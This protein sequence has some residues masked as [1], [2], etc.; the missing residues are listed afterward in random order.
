MHRMLPLALA[1]STIIGTAADWPQ[2]RGPNG[3]GIGDGDFPTF[4]GPA[5]NVLWKVPIGSGNSSPVIS[6]NR[7]FLNAFE[8][9][10]LVTICLDRG[11]GQ[12]LWRR[13]VKPGKIERGARHSNPANST[14]CTDG[15]TLFVYFGAFG[16]LAYNFDGK[17]LWRAPLPPLITQHG[18]SS[19][20]VLASKVVLLQR[21]ADVD[22]HL[23]ALN[24]QDG[25]IAWRTDRPDVRRGFSTPL[26]IHGQGERGKELAILAG[27]LRIA[28]YET[29]TGKEVWTVRG[30]PNEM[31]SSPVAG[32]GMLFAAGWTHG[33]GVSTMPSWAALLERGDANKDGQLSQS[34]APA[35]P[36]KQHFNYFDGNKNGLVSAGEWKALADIFTKAE[37]AALSIRLGGSGDVTTTHVAWKQTRGLPYVPT[38][39]L[40][41]G[42]LYMIKN[43]G[44]LTCLAATNGA[45]LYQEE[46]IGALGD[47]YSSPVAAGG[48][49]LLLSQSGT[50]TVIE[51]GDEMNVLAR[52][53]L[54]ETTIAT[55]AIADGVL[56]IRTSSALQAFGGR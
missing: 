46:R 39:L 36:A 15:K 18:A 28:A 19:S 11:T 32:D 25:S 8:N 31:C 51:M 22:A 38:P 49:L 13:A 7:L 14:P 35:G 17:E 23:L 45:A 50:A 1:F 34:E 20:P 30:L 56:Y 27:T 41:N 16:A 53:N 33:S 43:G 24:K 12:E 42:R 6:G 9:E 55:P 48:K 10:E 40:H 52:N 2:F 44:L 54:G 4:F 5:T 3:S 29:F 37:N 21:D 26:V 47:Y